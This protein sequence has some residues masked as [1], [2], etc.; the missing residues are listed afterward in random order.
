VAEQSVRICVAGQKLQ[1]K[2]LGLQMYTLRTTN[3][4]P[5]SPWTSV[6]V[7][8]APLY[9]IITILYAHSIGAERNKN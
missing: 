6:I 3:D 2:I 1:F 5:G 4:A 7:A 9:A 8:I